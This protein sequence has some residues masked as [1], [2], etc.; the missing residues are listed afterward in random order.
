MFLSGMLARGR[1]VVKVSAIASAGRAARWLAVAMWMGGIFYLSQQTAPLGAT[2]SNL[3]SIVAHLSLYTGLAFLFQWALTGSAVRRR[4]VF[5]WA[6]IAFALTV[7]YGVTDEV[8]QAFVPGRTTSLADIALDAAGAM[9]GV[10]LALLTAAL[11]NARSLRHRHKP[12]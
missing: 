6:L 5:G 1:T 3:E 8:H 2:V 10:G 7:L 9:L 11:L 12:A 4:L